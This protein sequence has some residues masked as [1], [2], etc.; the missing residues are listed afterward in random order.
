MSAGPQIQRPQAQTLGLPVPCRE[1]TSL[2]ILTPGGV[3]T[4]LPLRNLQQS[5]QGSS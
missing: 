1:N 2:T 3:G 5:F 4:Y